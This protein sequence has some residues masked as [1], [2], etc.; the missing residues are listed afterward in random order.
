MA[1]IQRNKMK[2]QKIYDKTAND[3]RELQPEARVMIE[4]FGYGKQWQKATVTK[5]IEPRSYEI[6]TINGTK[7]IR[8]RK[9]LRQMKQ[10]IVKISRS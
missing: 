1:N 7:L 2:Q 8:N 3:L 6:E 4:P 5:Q 9:H 10:N